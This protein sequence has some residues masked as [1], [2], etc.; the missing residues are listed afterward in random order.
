VTETLTE[1]EQKLYEQVKEVVDGLPQRAVISDST[2]DYWIRGVIKR[3]PDRAIWHAR[4]AGG[5]GGSEIGELLLTS[6]GQSNAYNTLDEISQSK[7]LLRL[8]GNPN[9]HMIRGTE[10]E[11]L[12]EIVYHKVS[13]HQSIL[14]EAEVKEAFKGSHP[15]YEFLVGNPDEVAKVR[16]KTIITDFKVRS[17]LDSEEAF[18]LVNVCQLHWY[19]LKYEGH[20]KK[21][22]DYYALAEM[23]I[24]SAL[25]D[26]LMSKED[27]DFDSLGSNIA[28]VNS[29]GFGMQIRTFRHNHAIGR[30]LLRLADTFWKENV[31]SGKPYRTPEPQKPDE[32]EPGDERRLAELQNE[33]LKFRVATQTAKDK[34][35][36]IR[37]QISIIAGKYDIKD[38]PFQTDG[39]TAGYSKKFNLQGAAKSLLAKGVDR[40]Q[41]SKP[42][43]TLDTE[44]ATQTLRNHGLLGPQVMTETWDTRKVKAALKEAE[45]EVS[46]FEE[47]SFRIGMSTT[48]ADAPIKQKL[49]EKMSDHIRQFGESGQPKPVSHAHIDLFSQNDGADE[50]DWDSDEMNLA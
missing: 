11:P 18:K 20:F 26:D 1:A 8:P 2:V 30:T 19:G 39:L 29:P 50:P 6:R 36:E 5:I 15:D 34:S 44:A 48:K 46:Q 33:Y 41:I 24:P 16:Q 23:D 28:A 38:W 43:E 42:S 7:L 3:E 25:I 35:D 13:G 22:P 17:N 21:L 45:I 40:G 49:Q 14:G 32:L 4:R 37:S 10:M 47:R 31:L 9:I 12:A 27:P